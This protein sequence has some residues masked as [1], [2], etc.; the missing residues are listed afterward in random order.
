MAR[1]PESE[2]ERLKN[3]ISVE[4]LIESA[5][6]ALAKAGKDKIG[7]CPFHQD[8]TASLVVTP[9]KNLWHCFGCQIGGGPIDWVM[10]KSA[11]SFRHAVELLRDGDVSSL[12]ANATSLKRSTIRTLAAPVT[13]DADNDALLA[14][15]VGYYH[16]TLKQSPE[17]LAYLQSRGLDHPDLIDTFKLGFANRTLGLRLPEKN[18]VAGAELRT[19]LQAV[20]IYRD[21]GHERYNGSLVVPVIDEAGRINEVYGRKLNDNLRAGTAKHLYLPEECRSAG[22]G[23]WNVQ[24]LQVSKEIILCEALID[25]MTFW[26]AGYRNVTAA[27]GTEGFTDDHLAAFQR[28]GT[29]RVLIAYDRDEAGERAAEKHGALLMAVG[30]ECWRIQFP[31]GMDAN[32]YALKVTPAMKSLGVAIRKAVW[33]G[34]GQPPARE[35]I[36]MSISPALQ[37]ALPA[38]SASRLAGDPHADRNPRSTSSTGAVTGGIA[39]EKLADIGSQADAHAEILFLSLAAEAAK[40]KIPGA[41]AVLPASPVPPAPASDTPAEVRENEIIMT[42]GDRRWRVRGLAKNVSYD[43]MKVNLMVSRAE[44]FH[45][46][47]INFCIEKARTSFAIQAATE[48]QV[49]EDIIKADLGRVLLKLEAL[50]DDSIKKTLQPKTPAS[51][52]I[53]EEARREAL[54][55]LA[56]PKL[57]DRIADDF[58]ACGIVGERINKLTGYLAAVSRKLDRPLAVVIQSSSAAGKSSLMDA[59]LAFMPEEERIKYSAMTGQSLFYMG[60][61]NLKNKILAIVEEEGA[62]KASYALKLLQSEGELTIAS[63]GKDPATGN[64]I[65]Q[66]Y[67]VEGPVMIFL[68]TTAIEI[69]EELMNR[70]LVLSVDEGREQTQAIHRLQRARRTLEGLLAKRER[71]RLIQLHRNAQRLLRPLFV[72]NPFADQLTF[73]SDKTRTRRDHEKYLTLIDAIA[74]LHQYQRPI[75]NTPGSGGGAP[76]DYIEVTL[77]DIAQANDIAHEVLGR[78]LDELPPQTRRLLGDV[79]GLVRTRAQTLGARVGDVRFTRKLVRDHVGWTDFQVKTHMHKL[80]ELEYVLVHRGGRGQSFEYE[81]LYDGQGQDGKPFVMGLIDVE[82]LSYDANKE[83]A[84]PKKEHPSSPQVAPKEHPSSIEQSAQAQALARVSGQSSSASP[85]THVSRANGKTSSYA[86]VVPAFPLA[87]V[88]AE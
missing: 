79:V 40:E 43:V 13:R 26:C 46:D 71:E 52:E 5:G 28:H 86:P 29:E 73:L 49:K 54:A 68:T 82:T 32:E 25:A 18:R 11:V 9:S 80:E 23:V 12:V 7:K 19:R 85:K 60:E 16:D 36:D 69:D 30:I 64:L 66:Q 3:E 45:L 37:A 31:K 75:K 34:K 84:K 59:V 74:L 57:L 48:L 81:L 6:I 22:R 55:L 62:S 14:Q 41:P 24:A 47:V 42:I 61:T 83:R 78:S 39:S 70:C 21:S 4:R 2:I 67:R 20:G 10:K 63:T 56:D 76:L 53:G 72:V 65:T 1:I 35:E 51:V 88:A 77:D 15:V 87:A 50:Q 17:A 33:L 44:R 58:D 8:D 38:A 27:Y